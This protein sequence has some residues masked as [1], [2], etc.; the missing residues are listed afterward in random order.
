M[1]SPS[2]D[3][4]TRSQANLIRDRAGIPTARQNEKEIAAQRAPGAPT[5]VGK[6]AIT[7]NISTGQATRDL[8]AVLD[9][10]GVLSDQ[11]DYGDDG[12]VDARDDSATPGSDI[13]TLSDGV[14]AVWSDAAN[15]WIPGPPFDWVVPTPL[16]Q[17]ASDTA[18]TTATVTYQDA[19]TLTFW[20]F[21]G[22]WTIT[23]YVELQVIQ[24]ASSTNLRAN[25]DGTAGTASQAIVDTAIY[26]PVWAGQQLAGVSGGRNVSI[27]VQFKNSAAATVTARQPY[28]QV[29]AQRVA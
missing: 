10:Q 22:V 4:V 9:A 11:T 28:I 1:R 13:N 2:A 7:S 20:L 17:D 21:P 14:V 15:S 6:P 29:E 23:A 19:A 5:V 24:T 26:T 12:I 8:L 18:S 16:Y 27:K 25:I 3:L